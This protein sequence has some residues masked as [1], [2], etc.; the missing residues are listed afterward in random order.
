MG[1]KK[2]DKTKKEEN[3]EIDKNKVALPKSGKAFST[4]QLLRGMRDIL[5]LEA[6]Y[7]RQLRELAEKLADHF[8]YQAIETPILE[9]RELFARGVGKQTDIVEKEMY[10]FQDAGGEN[11]CLRPEGTASI[12]RAYINHGMFNQPQ[13]V[14]LYYCGPMFRRDRPQAG[15][16]RQFHQACCEALGDEHPVLDAEL[17]SLCHAFFKEL[18]LPITIQINSLGCAVCREAYRNE[19]VN[20]YRAKRSLLCP[21]CKERLNRNPLR[22]LDCKEPGCEQLKQGAPQMLDRLDELCHTHF[23]KVIEYLDDLNLPY[24]INP[25]IVRGLDYYSRTVFEIWPDKSGNIGDVK[26]VENVKN[27]GGVEKEKSESLPAQSALAGGGRYD[28][29]AEILGG[30]PTPGVGFSIGLERVINFMKE[31]NI[32][33]K[34]P[35]IPKVFVAQ[36][37]EAARRKALALYHKLRGKIKVASSFSKDGLK[38][39]LEIANKLGVRYTLIIGQKEVLDETVIIRDM[40]AGIQ[41]VVAYDKV[42]G[43]MERRL[44]N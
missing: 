26:S 9:P 44:N 21:V 23:F 3:K 22:L 41:E 11:V 40:E 18:G 19:L 29:L 43:D 24:N 7:W 5:P 27:V 31:C 16:Y 37:G 38:A 34:A 4:P 39:Q 20:Y 12:V 2:L 10:V 30:R 35:E 42:V 36:L 6:P 33:P 28:T 32:N 13:P 8:G 17:I 1:R 14:K 25:Y 15:R